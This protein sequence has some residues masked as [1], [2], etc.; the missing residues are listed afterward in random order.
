MNNKVL[1][2]AALEK[3]VQLSAEQPFPQADSAKK[4]LEGL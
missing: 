4:A 3:A 1:A 2:K